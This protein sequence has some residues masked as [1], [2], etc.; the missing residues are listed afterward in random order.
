VAGGQ[1]GGIPCPFAVPDGQQ[2]EAAGPGGQPA[3][4]GAR[5]G[6]P[7]IHPG[8]QVLAAAGADPA[9]V[10]PQRRYSH[11]QQRVGDLPGDPAAQHL[12]QRQMDIGVTV[13]LAPALDEHGGGHWLRCLG[14]RP[15][16]GAPAAVEGHVLTRHCGRSFLRCAVHW[17]PGG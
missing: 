1:F 8:A 17:P 7:V 15:G 14:E 13:G 2:W 5:V 16:D 12:A 3:E 6:A 11:R 9:L 10:V 4:R